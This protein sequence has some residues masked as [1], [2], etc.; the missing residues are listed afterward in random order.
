MEGFERIKSDYWLLF[1]I[2]LLGALIGGV[3]LYILLGAMVCGIYFA[4]LNKIDG[5]RV[6][7]DD[8][9][10]GFQHLGPGLIVTVAIVVPMIVIYLLIYAPVLVAMIAGP[11]MSPE[12]LTVLLVGALAVDFIFIIAMVCFHTLL[13]FSFPLIVDRGL[14]G[15]A[16]MKTSVRAVWANLGGV[17]GLI[18]VNMVLSLI[19]MLTCG[20]GIY[21]LIPIMMA[22]NAMAY[23]QVFPSMEQ[24]ASDMP[25]PPNIYKDF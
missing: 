10:K 9:W 13:M 23:R 21:F 2:S 11:N 24:T 15:L 16:A 20:L 8:L 4:F 22:A 3:T 17:A 6:Q 18:G 19:G 5:K 25:P 7:L 14:G 1:A 12:E